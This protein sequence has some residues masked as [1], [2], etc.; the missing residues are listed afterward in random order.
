MGAVGNEINRK[1]RE[2]VLTSES[3]PVLAPQSHGR[4]AVLEWGSVI[5]SPHFWL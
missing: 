5:A 3:R 2:R 4:L 1:Q